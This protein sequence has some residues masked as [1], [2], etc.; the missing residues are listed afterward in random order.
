M[1]PNTRTQQRQVYDLLASPNPDGL[2]RMQIAVCLN[3]ERA[4]VC[5]RVAELRD[6]GVLWVIRK[7]I[8][9]ITGE[10][11]EFLTTCKEVAKSIPKGANPTK[12][13]KELTGKLF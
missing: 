10:R 5:R 3:I 6:A 13:D 11:A 7:G 1:T 8:C 9:P 12:V 2:T 4:S